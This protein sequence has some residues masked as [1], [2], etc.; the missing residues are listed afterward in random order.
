[1]NFLYSPSARGFFI[2]G[3]IVAAPEDAVA[4]TAE[5]HA[6]L[7]GA[8]AAGMAILPDENGAPIAAEQPGP[9]PELAMQLLRD[10]RARLL[11]QSDYTQMPDAPFSDEQRA[12]WRAYRQALRDLPEIVTDAASA[13]WPIAP[14]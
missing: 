7:M 10:K 8:Q 6:E 9:D 12:E 1:M 13:V 3:D 11:R 5:R 4:V 2:Q 14:A